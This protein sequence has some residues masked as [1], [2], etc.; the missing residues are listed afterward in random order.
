MSYAQELQ[1]RNLGGRSS[2]CGLS[3]NMQHVGKGMNAVKNC[4]YFPACSAVV[5]LKIETRLVCTK[6]EA[7]ARPE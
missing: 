1:A 3:I 5:M 4:G 7:V 2:G 6:G